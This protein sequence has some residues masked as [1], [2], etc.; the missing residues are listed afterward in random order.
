M[1][2]I[3]STNYHRLF[4]MAMLVVLLICMMS[5]D[6]QK[7][8]GKRHCYF[9]VL[10]HKE[11][12]YVLVLFYSFITEDRSIEDIISLIRVN[13]GFDAKSLYLKKSKLLYVNEDL[14]AQTASEGIKQH[15]KDEG[16][17]EDGSQPRMAHTGS[18]RQRR[19]VS[20]QH[21]R[22]TC[23]IVSQPNHWP[24]SISNNINSNTDYRS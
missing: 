6:W 11:Y 18:S 5:E 4:A 17:A 3:S 15:A 22:M 2:Q 14:K 12:Y 1:I 13:S 8:H 20:S 16:W 24:T 7:C 21:N 19:S 23:P 9:T 10:A